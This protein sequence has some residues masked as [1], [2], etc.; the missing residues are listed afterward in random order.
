[1]EKA[2]TII[3]CLLFFT[4]VAYS[5]N[6]CVS[7]CESEQGYTRSLFCKNYSYTSYQKGLIAQQA[8][9]EWSDTVTFLNVSE[10]EA[11][12]IEAALLNYLTS[13]TELPYVKY[14]P[15]IGS[16]INRYNR[17]FFA[18]KNRDGEPVIMVNFFW[19]ERDYDNSDTLESPVFIN[20]GGYFFWKIQYNLR[21][22]VFFSFRI[23]AKG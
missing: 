14:I 9:F 17:Q 12:I 6:D 8:G 3:I 22:K 23:N 7:H 10:L 5:Q 2:F 13:Y 11:D 16:N 21:T 4:T 19:K 18:Y 20:D 15:F 1:M